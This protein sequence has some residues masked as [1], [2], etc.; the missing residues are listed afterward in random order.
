MYTSNSIQTLFILINF[1]MHIATISMGLSFLY[2][3]GSKVKNSE[4]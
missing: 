3:K 1:L 4:F 2:V